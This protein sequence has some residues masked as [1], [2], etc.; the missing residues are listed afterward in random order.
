[1][2]EHL[3]SL[4]K[5]RI[6]RIKYL[7]TDEQGSNQFLEDGGLALTV[8]HDTVGGSHPL[9]AVLDTAGRVVEVGC[10]HG[11]NFPLYP[12]AVEEVVAVEP[13]RR[14]RAKARD[15]AGD[16]SVPIRVVD[17]PTE[18]FRQQGLSFD[19]GVSSFILCRVPYLDATLRELH[20]VIHPG[21]EY[22]FYEH[23]RARRKGVLRYQRTLERLG[24][25]Y[26]VGGCH[27]SRAIF[28]PRS[29]APR[30]QSR[31]AASSSFPRRH[32]RCRSP[33]RSS[34]GPFGRDRR[35][36]WT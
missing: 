17:S 29:R 33:R 20:R 21:G 9:W 14:L 26:V 4:V 11:V 22:R 24:Y 18:E 13:E 7:T 35:R 36:R 23:V 6:E 34:A 10:G 12:P 19:A 30:L 1:M 16:G 27:L 15:A 5:D 32:T 3:T 31:A 25:S 8:L 28:A 2:A